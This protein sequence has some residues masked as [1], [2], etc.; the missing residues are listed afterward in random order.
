MAEVWQRCDKK[1]VFR[2]PDGHESGT[3]P[4]PR[5]KRGVGEAGRRRPVNRVYDAIPAGR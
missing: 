3:L 2:T 4:P 5:L 1:C